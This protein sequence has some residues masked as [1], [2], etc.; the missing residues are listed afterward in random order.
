MIG[1][2]VADV[3]IHEKYFRD[4]TTVNILQGYV[5]I[6]NIVITYSHDDR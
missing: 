2:I 5:T 4:I 3:N 1:V 6:V